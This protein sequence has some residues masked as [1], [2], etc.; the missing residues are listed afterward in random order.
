MEAIISGFL[1]RLSLFY[2]FHV[3]AAALLFETCLKVLLCGVNSYFLRI[4][5]RD[6]RFP[7]GIIRCFMFF[8]QE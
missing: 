4:R 7:F 6:S 3:K 8:E 5:V 2:I 1:R